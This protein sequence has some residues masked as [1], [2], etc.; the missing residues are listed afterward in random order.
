MCERRNDIDHMVPFPA[1]LS[2]PG[3]FRWDWKPIDSCIVPLVLALNS[4]EIYTASSCCG[5][6]KA[7]GE[8]VLH[9]GRVLRIGMSERVS[10]DAGPAGSG[11][12]ENRILA[13][14]GDTGLSDAE[15]LAAYRA[16]RV[17]NVGR[18]PNAVGNLGKPKP[19]PIGG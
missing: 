11:E 9:D 8:I 7:D 6:G 3:E 14:I 15:N 17:G 13:R 1:S 2:Y 5:H 19:P 12:D 10:G 16:G 4:A 18:G